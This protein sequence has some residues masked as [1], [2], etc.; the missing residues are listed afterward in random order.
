MRNNHENIQTALRDVYQ[1]AQRFYEDGSRELDKII[2]G[3]RLAKDAALLGAV[4]GTALFYGEPGGGK[5]LLS[6]N[7]FRLFDDVDQDNHVS[8]IPTDPELPVS[9]VFGGTTNI[10]SSETVNGIETSKETAHKVDPL[11][12]PDT[13]IIELDES[14]RGSEEVLNALLNVY[15]NKRIYTTEGEIVYNGL[16]LITSTM[17]PADRRQSTNQVSAAYASRNSVGAP[18]GYECT[19]EEMEDMFGGKEPNPKEINPVTTTSQMHLLKAVA[20]ELM[21]SDSMKE[22]G[23]EVALRITKNLRDFHEIGE[24]PKRIIGQLRLNTKILSMFA[25]ETANKKHLN[26]AAK[27][28]LAARIGALVRSTEPVSDLSKIYEEV[29]AV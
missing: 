21:I 29:A 8:S 5:S 26:K 24:S 27:L 20:D 25:G 6:H 17:N 1:G 12:T 14:N 4:V 28:L 11:I 13:K 9:R 23:A 15:Q 3:D 16:T 19:R 18:V 7:I 2:D 22:M 10:R